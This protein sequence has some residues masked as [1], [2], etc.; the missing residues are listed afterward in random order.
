MFNPFP[1]YL[2]CNEIWVVKMSSLDYCEAIATG[3]SSSWKNVHNCELCSYFTLSFFL[4]TNHMRRHRSCLEKFSCENTKIE[5]YYCKDCDFKT[6][7][8]I[9]FKQHINEDH[10]LKRKFRKDLSSEDFCI[11]SYLCEKCNFET[12][13]SLKWFDHTSVCTGTKENLQNV[14]FVKENVIYSFD[15]EQ[16]DKTRWYYCTECSYKSKVKRNFK[17]HI[18]RNHNSNKR[19]ACDKCP[20]KTKDK[21][22]LKRHINLRHVD[23]QKGEWHNCQN[24]PFKTKLKSSLSR[25]IKN[26]HLNNKNVRW[27]ECNECSFKTKRKENL[28]IHVT[29]KHLDEEKIKWHKC[30]NC[31]YKCNHA[32]S[33]KRHVIHQHLKEGEVKWYECNDCSYKSKMKEDLK[34]AWNCPFGDQTVSVRLLS[35]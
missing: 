35:I 13:F 4:M 9:L 3:R 32:S 18:I 12:N 27:Y 11:R 14:S 22:N 23:E 20:Y 33:L 31:S 28:N 5:V 7:L 34:K 2:C 25:H 15:S 30:E 21:S 8:T 16:T 24:C 10:G 1:F 6:E 19:Y 26:L 29:V 17:R